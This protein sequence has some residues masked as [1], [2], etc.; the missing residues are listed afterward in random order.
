MGIDTARLKVQL[1]VISAICAAVAGVF[2]T[3]YNGG[4]GP[5]EAGVMKS[6]RYVA[7]V[8]VGGM[9]NYW[10]ALLWGVALNYFSLR[11]AF[12]SHDDAVFGL[13]LVLVMMV[14]PQGIG[15]HPRVA[16]LLQQI[17]HIARRCSRGA[18]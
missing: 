7:I 11:G 9:A 4:I 14:A 13:I 8:S 10:G 18:S 16:R 6:V 2:L 15:K 5:S 17:Q 12:G 1:F 3:H